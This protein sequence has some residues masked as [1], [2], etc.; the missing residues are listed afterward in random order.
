MVN[1]IKSLLKPEQNK[2]GFKVP[3]ENEFEFFKKIGDKY[4]I[5][6]I[7]DITEDKYTKDLKFDIFI[8]N[9]EFHLDFMS[10]V[11]SK[12]KRYETIDEL[13]HDGLNVE[14]HLSLKEEEKMILMEGKMILIEGKGNKKYLGVFM[15]NINIDILFDEMIII[16][17]S[18]YNYFYGRGKDI[19][20]IESN[21]G[22][23]ALDDFLQYMESNSIN[24][25]SIDP[26]NENQFNITVEISKQNI[27]LT[28]RPIIASIIKDIYNK[29][30]IEMNKDHTTE[31]PISTGLMKKN[32]INIHNQNVKRTFRFNFIK[33]KS[34]LSLSIRRFMNYDE[35]QSLGL[36]GLGYTKEAIELIESTIDDK[37]GASI[38]LGE[39]NSGKSTLLSAILNKIYLD[40]SKIISIENP[41]EIEMPYLQI[42]LTDTETAD[43][44]FKMTKEL[45]QKGI[46]R[47]NPNV[48]LMSEI[49]SKD[50][51]EFFVGLGLRGHMAL[52]TLHAGS[53]ANAI[54][55]LLKVADESE[56]K[57]ILNLF[58]HQ[59]LIA[60]K[61]DKCNGKGIYHDVA[62]PKCKGVGS[63]G[64]IPIYEI[65][66][67]SKLGVNDSLKDL[68][69]LIKN[70]KVVYLSKATYAKEL[71]ANN[72]IHK[73]DYER[74]INNNLL[75]ET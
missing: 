54:V 14:Y 70:G 45:A 34:G 18:I 68:E 44:K 13:E 55:I 23:L 40:K 64:M 56:I 26:I 15:P 8:K 25:A 27:L 71:Y 73:K 11:F 19:A 61:C 22:S 35:I 10:E 49:R 75:V 3:K 52:A 60:K 42:D 28:P 63:S 46:L 72:K 4:G 7:Y 37:N 69:S 67:F 48:V 66:K 47:H 57:N 32:L 24:D 53:I 58:I 30:M 16:G 31:V 74:I 38:I 51:I 62:C 41:V 50:E 29:A 12:F 20:F 6:E 2:D 59:E 39:T 65:C 36:K 1:K 43:E 33:I 5:S 9:K 17:N 21:H